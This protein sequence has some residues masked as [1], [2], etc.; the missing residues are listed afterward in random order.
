[1]VDDG[2]YDTARHAVPV[3]DIV[4]GQHIMTIE[5]GT[6]APRAGPIL[7]AVNSY[8]IRIFG[9]GGHGARPDVCID[10]IVTAGHIIVRLQTIVSREVK[11]GELGVITC[12]SIHG[13]TAPNI[14]PYYV[15]LQLTARA[16]SPEVQRRLVDCIRRVIFAE[17]TAS[18]ITQDPV[19]KE[20]MRAPATI[21]Q[22]GP[23]EVLNAAFA[24]Y[25]G[26]KLGKGEAKGAS[27]DFSNLALA[28]KAP[29]LF[30]NFGCVNAEQWSEAEKVGQ[31]A[32]N[33]RTTYRQ[34]CSCYPAYFKDGGGVY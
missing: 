18:G 21:N 10:P 15:E 32:S 6:V 1:M 34:V 7:A 3:P 5:A 14:I 19:I 8:E 31:T 12:G 25:F 4:L 27:E 30:W 13:G 16:Y 9:K 28:C 33:P 23:Y 17:C 11:P 24:D 26:D 2:L 22:Q 29:Y 20:L